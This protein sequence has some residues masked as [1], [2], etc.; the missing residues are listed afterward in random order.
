V[1]ER[2]ANGDKPVAGARVI[3]DFTAG[4]G[5]A[6]SAYTVSGPDG[7]FLLCNVADLGFGIGIS[8]GISPLRSAFIE[9][10]SPLPK[11]IDIEVGRQ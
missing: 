11:T 6:P 2:K 10:S 5:W 8:A 4:F 7:R 9:L 3:I 1:F